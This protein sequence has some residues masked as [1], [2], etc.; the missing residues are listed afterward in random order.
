[1]DG[2]FQFICE[3][4]L[5][6]LTILQSGQEVRIRLTLD[7]VLIMLEFG[8]IICRHQSYLAAIHPLNRGE[9][10]VEPHL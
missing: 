8:D 10:E 4:L 3:F 5:T 1:M 2:P 7:P 9:G 6:T